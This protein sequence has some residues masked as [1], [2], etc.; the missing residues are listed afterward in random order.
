MKAT[1][2]IFLL[3]LAISAFSQKAFTLKTYLNV[4]YE[5][6]D[7]QGSLQSNRGNGL[8]VGRLTL[9][10]NQQLNKGFYHELELSHFSLNRERFDDVFGLRSSN[11]RS[12]DLGF[13]YEAGYQFKSDS[14]WSFSVGLSA[15]PRYTWNTQDGLIDSVDKYDDFALT[16]SAIPRVRHDFSNSLQIEFSPVLNVFELYHSHERNTGRDQGDSTW[17]PAAIGFRIGLG[18]RFGIE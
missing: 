5:T 9:A 7:G 6:F 16:F 18:Y 14:K 12:F 1:L 15:K 13:R 2:T 4:D 11:T 17:T 8:Q 10:V 3:F